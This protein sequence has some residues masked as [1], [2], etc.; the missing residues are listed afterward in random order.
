MDGDTL[1]R[2]ETV[3]DSEI[4]VARSLATTLAAERTAL[5][6]DSVAA[7]TAT[8][9]QKIE[10]FQTIER[11]EGQRRELCEKAHISLP[12]SRR[13]MTPIIAGV[14]EQI[15]DRWRTL[16]DLVAGCRTAN[17]VNGYIINARR[18]Q[19]GQLIQIL[20][21]AGNAPITYGPGGRT[22]LKSHRA[23]ARA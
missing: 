6:G 20:R 12:P 4:E 9:A 5:T 17:E 11:I 21:G 16:L 19:V 14:S 2:L 8:A 22:H 3:L 18:G 10:L 23:L 13:G 7:V 1:K 15:A